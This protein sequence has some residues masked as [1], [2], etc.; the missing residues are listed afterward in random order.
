MRKPI[1]LI[2]ILT[3]VVLSV[4]GV[5]LSTKKYFNPR[6]PVAAQSQ[7]VGQAPPAAQSAFPVKAA[8][9]WAGYL[10]IVAGI[11]HFALNRRAVANYLGINKPLTQRREIS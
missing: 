8:H 6:P 7:T 5:Y 2:L 11:W 1:S 9:E 3:F 4:S 10:F